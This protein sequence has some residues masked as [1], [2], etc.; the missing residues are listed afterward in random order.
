MDDKLAKEIDILYA[1]FLELLA[2][3]LRIYYNKKAENENT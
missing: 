3:F 2:E 1:E